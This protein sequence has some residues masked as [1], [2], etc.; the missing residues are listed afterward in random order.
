M[1]DGSTQGFNSF[2]DYL[3]AAQ[4]ASPNAPTSGPQAQAWQNALQA[5]WNQGQWGGGGVAPDER[6]ASGSAGLAPPTSY[7]AYVRGQTDGNNSILGQTLGLVKTTAPIWGAALGA[8][9]LSGLGAGTSLATEGGLSAADAAAASAM[10]ASEMGLTGYSAVNPSMLST[11]GSYAQNAKNAYNVE[12]GIGAFGDYGGLVGKGVGAVGALE[13]GNPLAIAGS[14]AGLGAF[15]DYSG[16]VGKGVGA[17]GGLLGLA[18]VYNSMHNGAGSGVSAPPV[19]SVSSQA[20]TPA[21][22]MPQSTAPTASAQQYGSN[23]ADALPYQNFDYTQYIPA[24]VRAGAQYGAL[25]PPQPYAEGGQVLAAGPGTP[26]TQAGHT[27]S[28]MGMTNFHPMDG[29]MATMMGA[30][31]RRMAAPIGQN[32]PPGAMM[33]SG[34]H[35]GMGGALPYT[36]ARPAGYADGGVVAPAGIGVPLTGLPSPTAM[37]SGLMPGYMPGS[38][39][40]M[41]QLPPQVS[42][43]LQDMQQTPWQNAQEHSRPMAQA[44]MGGLDHLPTTGGHLAALQSI[45]RQ[46][47]GYAEGGLTAGEVGPGGHGYVAGLSGGQDDLIPARLSDGEYVM[48]AETVAHLGDGN[49]AA[50]A[51]KLDKFRENIRAHKR[52]ADPSEIPPKARA[53]ESYMP[54]ARG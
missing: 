35:G 27:W 29:R 8:E 31:N 37:S 4:A 7:D 25:P 50:G 45:H 30:A 42:K 53:L 47:V 43:Q 48:D 19:S 36:N 46:G 41:Q 1:D 18:G 40:N 23:A 6:T 10:D 3:A 16:A 21:Q 33:G 49:N 26:S 24:S 54:K 9:A 13:S 52:S 44:V 12:Q 5:D 2:A 28:G 17:V 20:G 22:Q 38:G 11:L 34:G 51:A 39:V 14:A 15:G 32:L